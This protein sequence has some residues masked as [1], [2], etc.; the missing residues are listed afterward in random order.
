M[1]KRVVTSI[2]ILAV[3]MGVLVACGDSNSSL[4]EVD[5]EEAKDEAEKAQKIRRNRKAGK[6]SRLQLS[7][8][9]TSE[10]S[11]PLVPHL[12]GGVQLQGE[13]PETIRGAEVILDRLSIS[14]YD[15]TPVANDEIEDVAPRTH[16]YF[17]QDYELD[18]RNIA[19]ILDAPLETVLPIPL[20]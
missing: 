5:T 16:I 17:S 8:P 6:N 15:A 1:V 10:P 3:L 2:I 4:V 13:L 11:P 14:G 7:P 20:N 19:L 9:T 12:P 18:A